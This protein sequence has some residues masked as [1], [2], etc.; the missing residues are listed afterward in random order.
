MNNSGLTCYPE[1]GRNFEIL[2]CR[3]ILMQLHLT[4][5]NANF[6]SNNFFAT[7][8]LETFREKVFRNFLLKKYI[9]LMQENVG[10]RTTLNVHISLLISRH[11]SFNVYSLL[12]QVTL[13]VGKKSRQ[14][15]IISSLSDV[16]KESFSIQFYWTLDVDNFCTLQVIVCALQTLTHITWKKGQTTPATNK[17]LTEKVNEVKAQKEAFLNNSPANLA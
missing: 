3:K 5:V 2:F 17:V 6:F 11:R 13:F 1:I 16:F 15:E 8:R 4:Q 7:Y 10:L 12:S 14:F 9:L